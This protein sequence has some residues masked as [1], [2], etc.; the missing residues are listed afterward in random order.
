MT[1]L[2]TGFLI[3]KINEKKKLMAVKNK[4]GPIGKAHGT[5]HKTWEVPTPF[6]II[7]VII[8]RI[9]IYL[10]AAIEK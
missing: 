4:W 9:M 10:D 5:V 8:K 1:S 6:K 3:L 7:I 2:S